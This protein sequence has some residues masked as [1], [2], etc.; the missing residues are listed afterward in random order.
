LLEAVVLPTITIKEYGHLTHDNKNECFLFLFFSVRHLMRVVFQLS[1]C[2]TVTK[3]GNNNNVISQLKKLWKDLPPLISF[4]GGLVP[5][6]NFLIPAPPNG[7]ELSI[8]GAIL[9]ESTTARQ[10]TVTGTLNDQSLGQA[11]GYL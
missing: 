10:A 9:P 3:V 1:Y 4:H 2:F 6:C 7:R 11:S 5:T 8:C